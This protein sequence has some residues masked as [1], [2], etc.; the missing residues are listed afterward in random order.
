MVVSL[1]NIPKNTNVFRFI[2]AGKP[3]Y[4]KLCDSWVEKLEAHHLCYDPEKTI[5]LCHNCHH[6][7]HFWPQRLSEKD[8]EKLL[9]IRFERKVVSDLLKKNIL[10]P[11]ALAKLVA[12]SR[13]AH[14]Q[15]HILK[16]QKVF[17]PVLTKLDGAK[18]A[19][20]IR[21]SLL[22]VRPDK[23]NTSMSLVEQKQVMSDQ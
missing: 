9:L 21:S 20:R 22:C 16:H 3:G 10:G 14:I 1:S 5:N 7:V 15:K 4:C 2:T 18:K 13:Q 19:K 12:P 23:L 11:L 17:K 8:K 6:K